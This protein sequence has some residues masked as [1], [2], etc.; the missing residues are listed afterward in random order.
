[1]KFVGP[2]TSQTFQMILRVLLGCFFVFSG[3]AKFWTLSSFREILLTYKFIPEIAIPLFVYGIPI[4]EVVLGLM[5]LVAH[6]IKKVSLFLLVLV[7]VFTVVAFVKYQNGQ[8]GNCGCFGQF[9]ER[10][11]NWWLFV[12]NTALMI[13]L[14]VIHYSES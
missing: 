12:E 9:I 8:V 14:S 2:L 11:N 4:I 10:K 1:M 6:C 3:I 5:L 7:F 13:F